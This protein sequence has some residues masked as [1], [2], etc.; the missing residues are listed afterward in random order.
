MDKKKRV[1]KP[2]IRF[3]TKWDIYNKVKEKAEKLDV[4]L[5]SFLKVKFE[6]WVGKL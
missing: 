1:K 3:I 4:P 6:E 5:A 2:E